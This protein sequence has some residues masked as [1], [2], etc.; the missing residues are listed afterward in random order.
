MMRIASILG[1]L[2]ASSWVCAQ[3]LHEAEERQVAY[4]VSGEYQTGITFQNRSEDVRRIYWLDYEGKR[5]LY[6]ELLAGQEQRLD[7]YLTHPW[8]VTDEQDRALDV[9]Y[10]DSRARVVELR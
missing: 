7:T 8:L 5:K 9:Y 3:E 1:L 4:S 2:A 6:S 10:P